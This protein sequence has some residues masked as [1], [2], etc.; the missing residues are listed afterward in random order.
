MHKGFTW[1]LNLLIAEE[2]LADRSGTEILFFIY[3]MGIE[4]IYL[5]GDSVHCL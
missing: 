1:F 2:P 3:K 5:T 4:N